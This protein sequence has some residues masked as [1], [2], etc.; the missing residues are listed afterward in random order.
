MTAIQEDRW[1]GDSDRKVRVKDCMLQL[2]SSEVAWKQRNKHF[3]R[4]FQS[5]ACSFVVK[6]NMRGKKWK[7]VKFW[8]PG[9]T[10]ILLLKLSLIN[11]A[12]DIS[13]ESREKP[14][15]DHLKQ[16]R[17]KNQN[18]KEGPRQEKRLNS[19]LTAKVQKDGRKNFIK[20][21]KK[22]WQKNG[23]QI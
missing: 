7:M 8:W 12:S 13:E 18:P 17:D 21:R 19:C 22:H 11:T 2:Q 23:T 20:R 16:W 10:V 4:N 1:A 14:K 6:K 3:Q 9:R 15:R 5:L